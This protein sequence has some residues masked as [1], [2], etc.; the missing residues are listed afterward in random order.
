MALLKT[1]WG[2]AKWLGKLLF[3]HV[4]K[5]TAGW[6]WL[7]AVLI[8]LVLL[9]GLYVVNNH[10]AVPIPRAIRQTAFQ[11]IW[12]PVLGLILYALVALGLYLMRLM[13][14]E[15]DVSEFPDIDRAWSE[16]VQALEKAGIAVTDLPLFLVFGQPAGGEKVFFE[17]AQLG[18][19]VSNQPP[20]EQPLHVYANRDAV[21]VTCP[22][23]SLLGRQAAVLTSPPDSGLNGAAGIGPETFFGG[24]NPDDVFKTNLPKKQQARIRDILR[25]AREEGRD[26]TEAEKAD[27]RRLMVQD[28]AQFAQ[29]QRQARPSLLR[30][31]KEVDRLKRRLERLCRLIV[32]DRQPFCPVNG[33]L[34]LI[35]AAATD[36]E[37]DA[38]DTGE[39]CQRDLAVA[40][41][42]LRVLCPVFALV[43][44]LEK[45]PGFGD[46]RAGFSDRQRHRRVGQRFPLVPDVV[47]EEAQALID[48]GLSWV[49]DATLP[50]WVYQYFRVERSPE[51]LTAAVRSNTGLYQFLGEMRSRIRLLSRVVT[52][53]LLEKAGDPLMFGGCY[54]AGTSKE[55]A[56]Q[57]FI[58]GVVRRPIEEQ[59]YVAWTDD[60]LAEDA[61]YH[62][63]TWLAYLAAVVLAV[64]D[65]AAIA[66]V[67][68]WL[69]RR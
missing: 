11:H 66:G 25:K 38:G 34:F 64:V 19:T 27:V 42:V 54:L 7:V 3:P 50:G 58:A 14:P 44:D 8:L 68:V 62:R 61:A 9:V 28:D 59:D 32:R 55:T 20:G 52:H 53:G 6:R 18:L 37:R 47:G 24:G 5:A 45:V 33:L 15:L 30:D 29:Q 2:W 56:E 65:V 63:R 39:L 48:R 21:F 12:L 41:Q 35:P 16:A 31:G 22:G 4:S 46:F 36:S 23:A 17:S 67:I 10:P 69:V 13:R 26:L 57:A 43:C 1:L 60:A 51:Q 40:H 49:G